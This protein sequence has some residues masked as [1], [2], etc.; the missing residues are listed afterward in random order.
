MDVTCWTDRRAGVAQQHAFT[1]FS[2]V[3]ISFLWWCYVFFHLVCIDELNHRAITYQFPCCCC[4]GCLSVFLYVY[5]LPSDGNSPSTTMTTK[6]SFLL[7]QDI[8]AGGRLMFRLNY[9]HIEKQR[10]LAQICVCT[11]TPSS[12]C[13]FPYT[14]IYTAQSNIYTHFATQCNCIF[15]SSVISITFQ[16]RNRFHLPK[17]R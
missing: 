11:C 5:Y 1:S 3:S 15:P 4:C 16:W 10:Q 6:S 17:H 8:R 13:H 14:G 2:S 9:V 12:L 7:K